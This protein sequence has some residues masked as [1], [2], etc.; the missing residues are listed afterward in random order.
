MNDELKI[1]KMSRN[2]VLKITI[3]VAPFLVLIAYQSH[4]NIF[5]V[6]A[7]YIIVCI[8]LLDFVLERTSDAYRRIQREL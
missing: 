2:D 4:I 5:I 6:V 1:R 8:H 3:D 7:S